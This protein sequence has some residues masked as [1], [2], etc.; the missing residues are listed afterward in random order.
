MPLG[1]T[2]RFNKLP[3]HHSLVVVV[4]VEKKQFSVDICYEEK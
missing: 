4:G 2:S 1:D 3:A